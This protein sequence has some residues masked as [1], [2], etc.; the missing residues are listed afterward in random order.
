MLRNAARSISVSLQADGLEIDVVHRRHD[1]CLVSLDT[2]AWIATEDDWRK[3]QS[4]L[5][6]AV[7]SLVRAPRKA[8]VISPRQP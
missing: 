8:V 7:S 3:S 5:Q 4:R 1:L 6:R 2:I